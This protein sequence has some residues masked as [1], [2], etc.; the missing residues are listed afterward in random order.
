MSQFAITWPRIPKIG[1][2]DA[3]IN[4]VRWVQISI[5]RLYRLLVISKS[6][7]ICQNSRTT[8]KVL[9][10]DAKSQCRANGSL[11]FYVRNNCKQFLPTQL[12]WF[13]T[14]SNYPVYSSIWIP[15]SLGFGSFR[16]RYS[17]MP[18]FR[19]SNQ[20]QHATKKLCIAVVISSKSQ[21]YVPIYLLDWSIF[22][23]HWRGSNC[24]A[25]WSNPHLQK[26]YIWKKILYPEK[27]SLAGKNSISRKKW[28]I[29]KHSL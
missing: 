17:E 26:F 22:I 14:G 9:H 28:F 7:L 15:D 25:F 8:T 20:A 4:F 19:W 13:K 21:R 16:I 5:C 1:T 18:I 2:H 29:R 12:R 11:H 24:G 27:N 23:L 3:F 10:T 6:I